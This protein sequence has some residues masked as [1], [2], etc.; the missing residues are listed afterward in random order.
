MKHYKLVQQASELKQESMQKGENAE[1]IAMSYSVA[2][3]EPKRTQ[4]A[5]RHQ[6]HAGTRNGSQSA[7][8][9][10]P[11]DM[12]G[13]WWNRFLS[14]TRDVVFTASIDG[15][16]SFVN[17]AGLSLLEYSE[18]EVY[19]EPGLVFVRRDFTRQAMRAFC[20]MLHYN[21]EGA[22]RVE[23]PVLA[24]SGKTRWLDVEVYLTGELS[25]ERA[26]C[27]VA[28]DITVRKREEELERKRLEYARSVAEE[29][30]EAQRDFL[31]NLSH[32]IRNPVNSIVGIADLLADTELNTIQG[33]YLDHIRHSSELLLALISDVL[34][35]SKIVEGKMEPC[36]DQLDLENLLSRMV[37]S[38]RYG[39]RDKPVVLELSLD[40]DIP[41]PLRGDATF[42][43]QVLQNL[44]GNAAKFTE[45][46]KISLE[47]NLC[48]EKED[49][50]LVCFMVT[51]TGI[52]IPADRL[53]G[54]F[55]RFSQL[56]PH[57]HRRSGG[58]GL[59]LPIT[60]RLVE[61]MGGDIG[62]ESKVGEGTR[63]EFCLPFEKE[64]I[65]SETGSS[66]LDPAPGACLPAMRVLIAE[67]NPVNRIY[68]EQTLDKWGMRFTSAGNG[69]EALKC[70]REEPFDL[71]LLD[72][73]MPVLDGL[74]TLVRLRSQEGHPN[75]HIPVIALTGAVSVEE[76]Q[77]ALEAG[78]D[79]FLS[80][81]FTPELLDRSIRN[82]LTPAPDISEHQEAPFAEERINSRLLEELYAGDQRHARIVFELFMKNTPGEL[83]IMESALETGDL[84]SFS[85]RLHKIKPNFRM[86]GLDELEQLA[87]SLEEATGSEQG[88]LV[89][90]T[91][92]E[93]FKYRI[94][95]AMKTLAPIITQLQEY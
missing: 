88:A 80:K 5:G 86:V 22:A 84:E 43:H 69:K 68:L 15:R 3:S 29:A 26:I 89:L 65:S 59:G 45:Q 41:R 1:R 57:G 71:C 4:Y 14:Y 87:E 52:G 21:P 44:L 11:Q 46:G 53:P 39:L 7:R 94:K 56:R 76:R 30:A 33:E 48:E 27:G 64:T 66:G 12:G 83:Q 79:E 70:L 81:P 47:V 55:D 28:R 54:I 67:D 77:E 19:G 40:P 93:V 34:D 20:R 31:G 60:K 32:E 62:V 63:F 49:R 6:V 38:A 18:E 35:F 37:R 91:Q 78:V 51:D 25:P 16:I 90:Y 42:L 10:L 50:A 61:L 36:N 8:G 92:F 23:V 95:R 17:D 82:V 72:I 24:Q 2:G 13:V 74:E 75:Q 85:E 73:R 58:I 9:A